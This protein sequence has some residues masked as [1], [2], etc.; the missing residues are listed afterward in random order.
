MLHRK[1]YYLV[2]LVV[3]W[4]LKVLYLFRVMEILFW[5]FCI[6][7]V[8]LFGL[9]CWQR[10]RVRMEIGAKY[11]IAQKGEPFFVQIRVE[12]R[13][14]LPI[15][16][17][18]IRIRYRNT[19]AEKWKKE[20]LTFYAEQEENMVQLERRSPYSASLEFVIEKACIYDMLGLFCARIWKKKT[21]AQ[22]HIEVKVLPQLHELLDDPLRPNPSVMIEGERYSDVLGGDDPAQVFD[23]REYMDGDRLNRIH[24]KMTVKKD[25]LMVKEFGLPIDS[26]VLILIDLGKWKKESERLVMQDALLEI[27]LSLSAKLL[28]KKQIHYLAWNEEAQGG[29]CRQQIEEEEDFYLAAGMLLEHRAEKKSIPTPVRYLAEYEK[30]QYSNIF[31]ISASENLEQ[32]A[33]MLLEKRKSAWLHIIW[34]G[35][36]KPQLSEVYQVPGVFIARVSADHLKEEISSMLLWEG[37]TAYDA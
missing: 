34:L 35:E 24:W 2:F 19:V 14:H 8:I 25:E 30:E 1:L 3:L 4:L 11:Q 7:P 28:Q 37:G 5:V 17:G 29:V 13:S 15:Y 22:R 31:Y 6:L 23:I 21:S 26:S 27:A 33:Q 32:E 18:E 9:L 12:N 36:K 20:T 10:S 16:R